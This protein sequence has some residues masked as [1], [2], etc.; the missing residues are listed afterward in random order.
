M[1]SNLLKMEMGLQWRTLSAQLAFFLPVSA[2]ANS[3]DVVT[4]EVTRS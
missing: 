2:A 3:F 1:F 4:H